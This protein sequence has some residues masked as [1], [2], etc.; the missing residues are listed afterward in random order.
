MGPARA[1]LVRF[2]PATIAAAVLSVMAVVTAAPVAPAASGA[3]Q[4]SG[5]DSTATQAAQLV[6]RWTIIVTERFERNRAF[7]SDTTDELVDQF[8]SIGAVTAVRDKAGDDKLRAADAAVDRFA[9]ES[10]KAGRRNDDG[11]VEVVDAAV[12][13]G[14]K[15][16]CPAYPFC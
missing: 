5:G 8:I 1:S 2:L 9:I 13:A 15:A 7:K 14:I 16:V 11:S 3:A 10:I 6:T 12:V 4:G